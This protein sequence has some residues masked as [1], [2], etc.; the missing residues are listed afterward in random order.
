MLAELGEPEAIRKEVMGHRD[1]A[2]KAFDRDGVRELS[3]IALLLER[4]V[5]GLSEVD[6]TLPAE[7]QLRSAVEANVLWS[8]RQL[9][10]TPEG[11]ARV[12]EGIL[13]LVGA[14]YELTTGRVRFL[15]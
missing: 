1:L 3:R 15:P 7:A 13:Q 8:M 10:D 2:T 5:P 6:A 4:I 9:L 12:E 11:R 14:V